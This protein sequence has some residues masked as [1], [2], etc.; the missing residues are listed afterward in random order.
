[1]LAN[2][3]A[4]M[5]HWMRGTSLTLRLA[6]AAKEQHDEHACHLLQVMISEFTER[7]KRKDFISAVIL[8]ERSTQVHILLGHKGNRLRK[9]G[10]QARADIEDFLGRPVYLEL[11]VQVRGGGG[12]EGGKGLEGGRNGCGVGGRKGLEGGPERGC[13]GG[14]GG[15]RGCGG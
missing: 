11:R 14:G 4:A 10:E 12:G 1:M 6:S 5:E 3:L 2:Q 8:M 15:E 13:G 9:L 7:P